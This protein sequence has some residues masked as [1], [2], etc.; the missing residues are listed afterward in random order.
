MSFDLK[1]VKGDLRIENGDLATIKGIEKLKQDLLKISTTEMGSNP[2][3]PWY[4]SLVSNSL[5]GNNLPDEVSFPMAR[6]QLQNAIEKLKQLQELQT[7]SGQKTTP[8]EQLSYIQGVSILRYPQD[9]RIIRVMIKVLT[10]SF[11]SATVSFNP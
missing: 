6:T 9:P 2:L 8:D 11:G 7:A 4:G 5:I 10:R 3:Q 1:I